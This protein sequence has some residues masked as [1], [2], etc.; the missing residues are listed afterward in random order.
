[1]NL[2]SGSPYSNPSRLN[3]QDV[4]DIKHLLQKRKGVGVP[5]YVRSSRY[6]EQA[7][8]AL[9][10]GPGL[11]RVCPRLERL[12]HRVVV[13]ERIRR[14]RDPGCR[15]C[16]CRPLGDRLL[17]LLLLRA[18]LARRRLNDLI[19][20]VRKLNL[21]PRSLTS[22]HNP[23]LILKQIGTGGGGRRSGE[24][25][26][27]VRRRNVREG[28]GRSETRFRWAATTRRDIELSRRLCDRGRW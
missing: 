16:R 19:F 26:R 2:L 3:S 28:W 13:L 14:N 6:L 27:N 18:Q 12:P 23:S 9:P 15:R 24:G 8:V 20:L 21:P 25:E 10:L 5:L 22:C 7:I 4:Q 1:M 17:L 11:E